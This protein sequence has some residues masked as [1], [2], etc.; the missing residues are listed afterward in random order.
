M[1][2][3]ATEA[4]SCAVASAAARATALVPTAAAA[5]VT[6]VAT[7]T[8]AAEALMTAVTAAMLGVAVTTMVAA[9]DRPGSLVAGRVIYPTRTWGPK[10]KSN[11]RHH[12][13]REASDQAAHQDGA[14]VMRER[15]EGDGG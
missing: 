4:G 5:T 2:A 13:S 1:A 11:L 6:M 7:V 8:G 10:E 14:T 9:V 15:G 3:A 12:L